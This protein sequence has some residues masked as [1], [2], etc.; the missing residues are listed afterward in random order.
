MPA[1]EIDGT[2]VLDSHAIVDALIAARGHG[3]L[4]PVREDRRWDESNVHHVVAGALDG[5]GEPHPT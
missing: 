5:P 2:L 3:T 4:R 1:A